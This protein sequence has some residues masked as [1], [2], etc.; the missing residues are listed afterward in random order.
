MSD[1]KGRHFEGE[2]VLRAVRWCLPLWGA[3][4]RPRARWGRDEPAWW[5]TTAP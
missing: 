2:I 3:L 5:L 1:F 4:M